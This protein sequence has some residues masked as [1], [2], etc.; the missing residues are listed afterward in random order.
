MSFYDVSFWLQPYTQTTPRL[1]KIMPKNLMANANN[2]LSFFQVSS[3]NFVVT[4]KTFLWKDVK[5]KF[6]KLFMSVLERL[7]FL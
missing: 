4:L 6:K 2:G 1:S 5:I 7:N 3:E